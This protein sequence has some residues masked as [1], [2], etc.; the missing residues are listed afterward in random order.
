[1]YCPEVGGMLIVT[2]ALD[3][4]LY[5]EFWTNVVAVVVAVAAVAPRYKS[6]AAAIAAA[7]AAF[8]PERW[9]AS[10]RPLSKTRPTMPSSIGSVRTKVTSI[11]PGLRA[12]SNREASILLMTY[13]SVCDR[14]GGRRAQRER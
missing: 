9:L 10:K 3:R 7:S 5:E 2:F 13:S 6:M 14:H 8:W 12:S 11:F 4:S 1:M